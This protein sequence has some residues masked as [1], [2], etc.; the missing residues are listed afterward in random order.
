M[1]KLQSKLPQIAKQAEQAAAIVIQET[2]NYVLTLIRLYAP[3]DTG[4]LRD[5]YEKQSISQLHIV[6]GTAVF[7]SV[8]QEYGT[9][10][11]SGTPHFTPAFM[12][13]ESFFKKE[14]IKRIKD[15]G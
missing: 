2:A 9:S 4:F 13:A 1:A 12:Q 11:Q 15:L 8:F 5:S 6:I 7:Y 3:V 10:R 14:L